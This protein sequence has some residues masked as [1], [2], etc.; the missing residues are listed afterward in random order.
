MPLRPAPPRLG[1]LIVGH[2]TRDGVGQAEFHAT[3]VKIAAASPHVLVQPCFLELVEPTIPAAIERVVAAGVE[4]IVVAPLL[5]FAAGHAKRDVPEAIE[6]ARH[7]FP[8]VRFVQADHLGCHAALLEL[9]ARRFLDAQPVLGANTGH[10]GDPRSTPGGT[11]WVMVGR[12]SLDAEATAECERFKQLR[13]ARTPVAD[14]WNGYLAMAKPTLREI[15]AR[16]EAA[17]YARIVVQPHLLFSGE[18]LVTARELV[19]AAAERTPDK[20]WF[21][22]EHLGPADQVAAAVVDRCRQASLSEAA[23]DDCESTLVEE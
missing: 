16:V 7:R 11:L 15:L 1:Y 23:A 13:Q 21:W 14:A 17:D 3:V 2:G 10:I 12:G 22:A 9:S 6:A 8:H 18:L 4:Q 5:L 20:Q 19:R